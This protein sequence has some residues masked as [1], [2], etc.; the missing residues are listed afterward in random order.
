MLVFWQCCG[1]S[2][3][4]VGF[5]KSWGLERKNFLFYNFRYLIIF[6]L[7]FSWSLHDVLGMSIHTLFFIGL[8]YSVSL[9]IQLFDVHYHSVNFL[10]YVFCDIKFNVVLIFCLIPMRPL[11]Y[12][13]I[14]IPKYLQQLYLTNSGNTV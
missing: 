12:F 8:W 5:N 2:Y 3:I 14:I 4:T 11:P 6:N 10:N 7:V 9:Y 1:G 13:S